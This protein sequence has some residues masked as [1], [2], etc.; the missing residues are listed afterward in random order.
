MPWGALVGGA[1]GL[2]GAG[3]Q[4]DAAGNAADA[5]SRSAANSTAEQRR[6]FDL[7]QQM[8]GPQR[9]LGYSAMG[10]LGKLYG[11]GDPNSQGVPG[12]STGGQPPMGGGFGGGAGRGGNDFSYGQ[13]V[14]PGGLLGNGPNG[15]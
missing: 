15:R 6:E 13:P 10:A 3:M 7:V 11:F 1:I 14:G 5:Q 4:S 2:I 12:Y 9:N 8:Y